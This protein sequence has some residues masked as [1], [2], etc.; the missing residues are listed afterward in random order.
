MDS[1]KGPKQ[2]EQ[3][4]RKV[5]GRRYVLWEQLGGGGMAEVWK[6]WDHD[7]GRPDRMVAIKMPKQADDPDIVSRFYREARAH[8]QL[9]GVPSIVR[10]HG[11]EHPEGQP[12]YMVLELLSKDTLKT[13]LSACSQ[14]RMSG[15]R[16]SSGL[17]RNLA[18][19]LAHSMVDPVKAMHEQ[20]LA[21]R[22]LKPSNFLLDRAAEEV[23]QTGHA[24]LKLGD[25][26]IVHEPLSEGL[27]ETQP[28]NLVGTWTYAPPEYLQELVKERDASRD[29]ESA[30]RGDIYAL[31]LIFYELWTGEPL[32]R[33]P[34]GSS[35]STSTS[36]RAQVALEKLKD[37]LKKVGLEGHSLSQDPEMQKLIQD[38]LSLEPKQRP[39]L[40]EVKERLTKLAAPVP[41]GTTLTGSGPA[42]ASPKVFAEWK[43]WRRS[44]WFKPMGLV[45]R[46][47][48][49]V[50]GVLALLGLWSLLSNGLRPVG[51]VVA[52]LEQPS[53]QPA[54]SADSPKE[55]A[56]AAAPTAT[57]ARAVSTPAPTDRSAGSSATASLETQ[58]PAPETSSDTRAQQ[59]STKPKDAALLSTW[60][61]LPATSPADRAFVEKLR[62]GKLRPVAVGSKDAQT[63]P[64]YLVIT[65]QAGSTLTAPDAVT[66]AAH[67]TNTTLLDQGTTV[68]VL[69]RHGGSNYYT[70][71]KGFREEPGWQKQYGSGQDMGKV[72]GKKK[73]TQAL[74]Y[75]ATPITIW[76]Q[77][78]GQS[79]QYVDAGLIWGGKK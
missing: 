74:I 61:A 31:G 44:E 14:D 1:E 39:S 37:V 75:S 68:A 18:L 10:M 66:K 8:V 17:Y 2:A 43:E 25:L 27:Q 51:E 77:L 11:F 38:M 46:G 73:V 60:E 70:Q 49:A 56:S 72:W 42:T 24:I 6:G 63:E 59:A 21:H 32:L 45:K 47:G 23:R 3:P 34:I 16:L 28:G 62:A 20:H 5:F 13:L 15:N 65:A 53:S 76:G 48:I 33:D 36:K 55:A 7:A 78:N 71:V 52:T 50:V 69:L 30:K 12:P 4:V 40:A 29:L 58:N 64:K 9:K 19:Y 67:S 22:D 54:L 79:I 41:A 35:A 26:G 57:P